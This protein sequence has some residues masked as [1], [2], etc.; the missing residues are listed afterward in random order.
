MARGEQLEGSMMLRFAA[1]LVEQEKRWAA[2][3]ALT[4]SLPLLE[5]PHQASTSCSHELREVSKANA[6]LQAQTRRLL[7]TK[8]DIR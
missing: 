3:V 5:L 1:Q 2:R 7:G 4:T 6:Q 8:L